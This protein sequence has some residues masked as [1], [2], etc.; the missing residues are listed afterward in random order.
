[1]CVHTRKGG[2]EIKGEAKDDRVIRNEHQT[3][4]YDNLVILYLAYM[5]IY[6]YRL[7]VL[8]DALLPSSD[9][10]IYLLP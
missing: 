2:D 9:V 5:R 4:I 6:I 8:N 10:C 3:P 7:Y 1:M